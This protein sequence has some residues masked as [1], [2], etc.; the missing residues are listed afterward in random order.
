MGCSLVELGKITTTAT[1]GSVTFFLH[2]SQH[3]RCHT[4]PEPQPE[5]RRKHHWSHAALQTVPGTIGALY[6]EPCPPELPHCCCRHTRH[7]PSHS[8]APPAP[9]LLGTRLAATLRSSSPGPYPV[10]AVRRC[11]AHH[12]K[13]EKHGRRRSRCISFS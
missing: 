13:E 7:R 11:H 10:M 5:L 9:S 2:V 6:T 8:G 12:R 1:G 4:A 3:Q